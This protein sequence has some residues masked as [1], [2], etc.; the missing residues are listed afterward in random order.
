MKGFVFVAPVRGFCSGVER[1]IKLVEEALQNGPFPVRVLHEIV[2]N[3]HVVESFRS[4]GVVFSEEL[5]PS[6]SGGT[7]IFSAHGVSREIEVTARKMNVHLLDAT[8]P[9]VKGVHRRAAELEG[10]GCSLILIGKRSHREIEGVIGRLK[11]TPYIVETPEDLCRLPVS[12]EGRWACLTQTTLSADD[13][14]GLFK[15]LEQRIPGI[16]IGSGICGATAARQKAVRELAA[17]CTTIVVIGSPGSSNSRKLRDMAE[18]CGRRAL[19]ISCADELNP[20]DLPA[21]N[22]GVTSG[23]SA[24][25]YLLRETVEKLCSAGWIERSP[26]DFSGRRPD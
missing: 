6:W 7:L 20:A 19:L 13:C 18:S 1:A 26:E 8:C 24:P 5:D 15:A 9:I 2:H 22:I 10:E 11:K 12:P 3:E 25:E 16:R 23:A 14:A 21:G 4:R 17:L